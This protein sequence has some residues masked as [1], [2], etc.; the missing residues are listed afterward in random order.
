MTLIIERLNGKTYNLEQ[1]GIRV[2]EFEPE[3]LNVQNEV[4]NLDG[5]GVVVQER[6]YGARYISASFRIKNRNLTD[7]AVFRSELFQLFGT[8]EQFYITDTKE[9]FKRWRV[10]T[11]GNFNL[12]RATTTGNFNI[13]FVCVM[14]FA[15]SVRTSLDLQHMQNSQ[16]IKQW[17]IDLWTWNSGIDWNST[18]QYEQTSNSFLIHNIGDATI[19]PSSWDLEI[20][21]K[22]T[23]STFFQLI[24][25][26]TGDIY[27]F[28]GGLTPSDTLI[29]RGVRTFK[30]D[31]PAFG[32]TN[33]K[34]ISLA[35]GSNNF[36]VNGASV[37]S[38]SFNFRYPYK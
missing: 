28:Y 5:G 17:D 13:N 34:L 16:N 12:N 10:R 38:I 18:Y 7:Y 14:I 21:I 6:G 26:T 35:P 11:D 31:L 1:L 2:V 24:N 22:A 27:E 15:E 36:R 3:S 9:S 20:T 33:R 8:T 30:N 19:E 29:I 25:F 23:T 32:D 37:Q 4:V